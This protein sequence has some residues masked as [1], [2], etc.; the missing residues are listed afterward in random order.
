MKEEVVIRVVGDEE[1][2]LAVEVVIGHADAHALAD[3]IANAPLLRDVFEG[4]VALVEE[5][6]VRLAFVVARMAVIGARLRASRAAA[7]E[8]VHCR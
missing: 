1:V 8:Y 3:V 4:A 2:G 5:E 6:L 7:A